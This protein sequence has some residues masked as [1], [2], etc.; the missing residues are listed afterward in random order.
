MTLSQK[1]PLIFI[2]IILLATAI[3]AMNATIYLYDNTNNSVIT[4]S[5]TA[6]IDLC[7]GEA[8]YWLNPIDCADAYTGQNYTCDVSALSNNHNVT[9]YEASLLSGNPNAS[10]LFNN[11]S[12]DGTLQFSADFNQSGDFE[13]ELIARDDSGCPVEGTET[14]NISV[15]AANQSPIFNG[16]IPNS[17]WQANTILIPYDLD[18]YF[19]D[20]QG[21]DLSYRAEGNTQIKITIA[22]SAEVTFEPATDWCGVEV[23][24]FIA[25][26]PANLTAES[27]LVTLEVECPEEQDTQDQSSSSSGGGGGGGSGLSGGSCTEAYYCYD[28]S[29]CQ[30]TKAV[31]VNDNRTINITGVRGTRNYQ[32]DEDVGDDVEEVFYTGHRWR[33]CIDTRMCSE[34]QLVYVQSCEYTP[35]CTDSIENGLETGVDCGGP[36]CAPCSTC[37]DG[38]QNGL[39]TGVDCGGPDC[40]VCHTCTDGVINGLETG[41]DCGGPD[42]QA[43]E[44]NLA[45]PEEQQ[46]A[47]VGS[48]LT[49][50][51]TGILLA[52]ISAVLAVVFARKYIIR[53]LAL[54]A[55]KYK[56]NNRIVLLTEESKRNLLDELSAFEKRRDSLDGLVAQQ[57]VTHIIRE[58]YVQALGLQLESGKKDVQEAIGPVQ[59]SLGKLLTKFFSY[60]E[61]VEFSKHQVAEYEM[62]FLIAEFEQIIYQT[63]VLSVQELRLF[64]EPL[65]LTQVDD[66]ADVFENITA[67]LL[68][69]R[70]AVASGRAIL[71]RELYA[72]THA[73]YAELSES[74][75]QE[76]HSNIERL[77]LALLVEE[78]KQRSVLYLN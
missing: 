58:Y 65:E 48:S 51:L 27:N 77:F 14:F 16:P 75:K 31:S 45:E 50:L 69:A 32:L 64:E 34:R 9:E 53:L 24:S 39:E 15:I 72:K 17:T 78:Y 56:R 13:V 57:E 73:L 42:C 30:Y 20:P 38:I 28:W 60:S 40:E 35:T 74:D 71:G 5:A 12:S 22:P 55:Q 49:R 44:E 18:T 23:V 52:L 11:I 54:W 26:N 43:C 25:T 61:A 67:I 33:E 37:T 62:D 6:T 8:P 4:G 7:I 1:K 10:Q 41:V 3:V 29:S 36:N 70:K 66:D 19:V 59:E 47:A 21:W 46:P 2:S 68:D 76:L 63:S